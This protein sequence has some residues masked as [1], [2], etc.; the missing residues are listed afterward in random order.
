VAARLLEPASTLEHGLLP[1]FRR[2]RGPYAFYEVDLV[3]QRSGVLQGSVDP[4]A[5]V[6]ASL[7]GGARE[8]AIARVLDRF[9]DTTLRFRPAVKLERF[10]FQPKERAFVDRLRAEPATPAELEASWAD[11]QQ[12]HRM[13]YLLAITGCVEPYH[14][15]QRAERDTGEPPSSSGPGEKPV[16]AQA[17]SGAP[18]EKPAAPQPASGAP[19]RPSTSSRPSSRAPR[20]GGPGSG[21]VRKPGEPEP[22]PQPPDDLPEEHLAR[23]KEIAQRADAIDTQTYFEMLGVERTC[24][25]DEVEKA[26]FEQV[27]RWHPDKLPQAL[28]PLSPWVQRIFHQLTQAKDT[29]AD[30]DER[31]QYIKA[32]QD[33][34][35]TPRAQR[36]LEA[37]VGAAVE[38]QKVE[39]LARKRQWNEAL[40]ILDEIQEAN[41]DEPDF[42]A[43][44]AWILYNRDGVE[45]E[46]TLRHTFETLDQALELNENNERAHYTKGLVLKR[47]GQGARALKHFQRV[48][49]L[50]PRHIDAAREVRL[51]SM[52]AQKASGAQQGGEGLWSKLFGGGQKKK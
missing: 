24:G 26:Y 12:V 17:A 34:G 18:S 19:A 20:E 49:E 48:T 42:H 32:V 29:L 27:K 36:Q 52:R 47:I 10:A 45:D 2:A 28:Q 1:L 31:G 51:A 35:G 38:F 8:D 15:A 44:R 13:L 9:A 30:P 46:N 37:I 7:R 39:V 6:T 25:R 33:G 22:A 40:A 21:T 14:A 3:G 4:Y 50:N 41:P 5:L 16:A 11:P 23:W 43:M